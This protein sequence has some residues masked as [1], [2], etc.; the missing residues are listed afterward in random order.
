M[1]QF[2]MSINVQ[3]QGALLSNSRLLG[4]K[5]MMLLEI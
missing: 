3:K 1:E 2:L 4:M 5:A